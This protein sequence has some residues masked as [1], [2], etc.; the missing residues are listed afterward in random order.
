MD[1]GYFHL[2]MPIR[3]PAM[4][5]VTLAQ[6]DFGGGISVHNPNFRRPF[7]HLGYKTHQPLLIGMGGISAN[8]TNP[9]A[10]F[11]AFVIWPRASPK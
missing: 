11:I 10:D 7:S 4:R 2:D 8:G 3:L 9:G 6:G 1:A 5:L